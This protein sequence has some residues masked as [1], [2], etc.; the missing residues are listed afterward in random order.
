MT[1]PIAKVLTYVRTEDGVVELQPGDTA[2][3]NALTEDLE[4]LTDA[5]AL[6]APDAAGPA[7]VEEI[8]A[9]V[10]DDQAAAAAALDLERAGKNRKTLVEALEKIAA[11]SD[12]GAE[13]A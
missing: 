1:S 10:G 13:Q 5:G 11:G 7:T 9:E 12:T 4:R 8:L 6:V 3:D 2:P